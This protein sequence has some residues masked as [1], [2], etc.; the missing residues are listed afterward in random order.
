MFLGRAHRGLD[1]GRETGG[2]RPAPFRA[3]TQWKAAGEGFFASRCKAARDP[4]GVGGGGKKPATDV[5]GNRSRARASVMVLRSD[6]PR[7]RSLVGA[8]RSVIRNEIG[9]FR[10]PRSAHNGSCCVRPPTATISSWIRREH[11]LDGPAGGALTPMGSSR[12]Q[13]TAGRLRV[14]YRAGQTLAADRS[15]APWR[16]G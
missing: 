9:D 1:S 8:P 15:L 12:L 14:P 13:R 10:W 6:Q 5:A 16:W 2:D 4:V 11:R 3:G 7:S